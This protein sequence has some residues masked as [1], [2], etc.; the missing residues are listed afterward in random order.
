MQDDCGYDDT[1]GQQQ[2]MGVGLDGHGTGVNMYLT[3]KG[4]HEKAAGNNCGVCCREYDLI[5]MYMHREDGGIQYV[6]NVVVPITQ[7][8][9]NRG[10]RRVKEK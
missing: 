7:S 9:K 10:R 8:H 1:E 4:V 6:P 5:I 3:N 2:G